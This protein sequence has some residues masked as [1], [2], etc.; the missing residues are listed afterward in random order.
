MTIH[1]ELLEIVRWLHHGAPLSN[2]VVEK[3]ARRLV[4]DS[5]GCM[6]AGFRKPELRR[7]SRQLHDLDGGAVALP[8][9]DVSLTTSHAAFLSS[10]GICWDEACE[11]LS[12]AH[13]RP[14]LHSLPPALALGLARNQALG[15]VLQATVV[16]YEVGARLGEVMRIRP[17][18]HVDGTWGSLGAAA[19]AADSLGLSPEQTVTAIGIVACQTPFSLYRP[20]ANGSTARNTY[21]AHGC[22]TA[23]SSA[24]ASA[25]EVGAPPDAID[26]NLRLALAIEP[27]TVALRPKGHWSIL[28]GYLKPYAAVRHVHYGA[29]AAATWREATR[30]PSTAIT[31]LTLQVYPEA[32]VY[33]GNRTPRTAIQ[34]QFSLSYGLAWMLSHG[35]LGPEAYTAEALSNAEVSRLESLV[36]V[37][38]DDT[39]GQAGNRGARLRV[40][41]EDSDENIVV[42]EVPGDPGRP[43]S[44]GDVEAKFLRYAAPSVGMRGARALARNVLSGELG[45]PLRDLLKS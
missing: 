37:E 39:L 2:E 33:C 4:L 30:T 1:S 12:W 13:G 7:L 26:E 34:A 45:Q 5:L 23:I 38:V 22:A 14:G 11:G 41:T 18:M 42:K 16:G 21:A 43:L 27:Q 44:T 9:L 6:I 10:V 36:E 17:G 28:D 29:A 19:A 3:Q 20:V 8:G 31:G 32:M 24:V 35:D 25:S 40:C 15:A